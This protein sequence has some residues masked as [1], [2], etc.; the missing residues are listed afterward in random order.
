MLDFGISR[1]CFAETDVL[2]DRVVKEIGILCDKGN[3]I[4]EL[5]ERDILQI[6]SADAD[7]AVLYVPVSSDET[8]ECRFPAAACADKC[9]QR[10]ARD[11]ETDIV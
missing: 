5:C 1:R 6:V 7:C 3:Q 8:G 10:A 9:V 11:R 2:S 4:I